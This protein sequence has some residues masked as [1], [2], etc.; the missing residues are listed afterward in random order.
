M[1]AYFIAA[2][3]TGIGKTFVTCALVHALRQ[4]GKPVMAY[5]PLITGFESEESDSDIAHIRAAL[6][7]GDLET[8]SPWRFT[9]P[10]SPDMAATK[11]NRK[12]NVQQLAEWLASKAQADATV[13]IETV[14][15]LMVPL[16]AHE[17]TRD[18]M[19]QCNLPLIMVT[20]S[21]L[22]ALSHTLTALEAARAAK[23]KVAA[24]IVNETCDST[25]ELAATRDSIANHARDIP[26]IVTQ[27]RVSSVLEATAI[28]TL[29]D[30][31]C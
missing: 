4:K 8:L 17:T 25:V 1:S 18:W 16:N 12:I 10:L 30:H 9:H 28:H 15:G 14:G 31:L 24:L 2:T 22:G 19:A 3:G 11:E 13:L 7:G 20:G 23:L 5:K 26:L 29:A 21:Y 6:G 27:A